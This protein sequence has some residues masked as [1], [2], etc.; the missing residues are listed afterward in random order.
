MQDQFPPDDARLPR[1]DRLIF[2]YNADGGMVNGIVDAMHKTLSPSTYACSLCA[3]T[4][5]VFTMSPQWRAWLKA[6]QVRT[7]FHHRN[8]SPYGPRELP[9]VLMARGDRIETAIDAARLRQLGTVDALI[10]ALEAL[11]R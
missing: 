6:A 5:G 1:I 3:I 8:D 7:E 4:H 11:L 9:V 2:I 10:T